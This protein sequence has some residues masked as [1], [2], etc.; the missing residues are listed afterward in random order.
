MRGDFH[1]RLIALLAEKVS[2]G[3]CTHTSL[4]A[5][6]GK[7][8]ST[9]G[10]ILGKNEGTL[11][12]D[13]AD[14][15]LRHVGSNLTDFLAT[16]PPRELTDVERLANVLLT[17][18]ALADLVEDLLPV[19]KPR[20]DELIELIRGLGR[21]ASRRRAVDSAG[22]GPAPTAERS[23]KRAAKPRRSAQARG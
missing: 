21:L 22:S 19:P 1:K 13:E 8:H 15:A 20:L 5:A 10:G 11:D 14:A 12:V 3:V 2:A 4:A 7:H 18:P 17:R 23:T 6:V 9:I 16:V